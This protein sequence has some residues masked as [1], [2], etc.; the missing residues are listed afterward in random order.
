[1]HLIENS[2]KWIVEKSNYRSKKDN[3]TIE[4]YL[5]ISIVQ[6]SL[7]EWLSWHIKAMET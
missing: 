3:K 6:G 5:K 4:E 2:L 1:M 7:Y